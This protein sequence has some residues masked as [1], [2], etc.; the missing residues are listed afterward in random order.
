[1]QLPIHLSAK[2]GSFLHGCPK[3]ESELLTLSLSCLFFLHLFSPGISTPFSNCLTSEAPFKALD[4]NSTISELT[5]H[6]PSIS[7]CPEGDV[8]A[9]RP[10][11]KVPS[12]ACRLRVSSRYRQSYRGFHPRLSWGCAEGGHSGSRLWLPGARNSNN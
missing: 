11:G 4:G 1:M 6:V 12:D 9:E 10:A 8:V 3:N 7:R 5:S 2:E